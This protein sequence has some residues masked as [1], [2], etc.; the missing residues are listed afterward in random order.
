MPERFIEF[1]H[2]LR[3]NPVVMLKP[4]IGLEMHLQL[5]TQTKMFC[6]CR[7]PNGTENPNTLVCPICLGLPGALPSINEMAVQKA[8]LLAEL[9]GSTISP[10][11]EFSRKHYS[12]PDLPKG[13]QI[14]QHENPIARGGSLDFDGGT[15]II[16]RIQLEEDTAKILRSGNT[17]NID[18]NRAGVPLCEIV[19]E[20]CLNDARQAENAAR[21]MYELL[22]ENDLIFGALEKG[23]LRLEP[24]I[25]LSE[26]DELPDYKVE[27]KNI[28]S[29]KFLRLAIEFEI[30]R[31]TELLMKGERVPQET[32]GYDERAKAT[33]SQRIKEIS[34]DYR[35]FVEPDLPIQKLHLDKLN[36]VPQKTTP[37]STRPVSDQV[38]AKAKPTIVPIHVADSE[39]HEI[40]TRIIQENPKAVH[41]Y[42]AGKISALNFL[43]GKITKSNS[44]PLDTD[45]VKRILIKAIEHGS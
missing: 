31:Q 4:I 26:T 25:S 11:L 15:L 7:A 9:L 43:I 33:V 41:D 32:R 5:N 30:V 17:I 29:F 6:G 44:S 36:P 45:Q 35:Y 34:D 8:V 13:Y 39:L 24:N 19:S 22:K 20:A 38:K 23:N 40:V 3:Y 14:S 12:Y 27:I 1:F 28:N 2:N 42:Q 21:K 10:I 16:E 37:N 18:H